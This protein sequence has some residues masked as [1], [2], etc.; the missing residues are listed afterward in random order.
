M[1]HPLFIHCSPVVHSGLAVPIC[2]ADW[3]FMIVWYWYKWCHVKFSDN[4][5]KGQSISHFV[6]SI[7]SLFHTWCVTHVILFSLNASLLDKEVLQISAKVVFSADEAVRRSKD[8][9]K[10]ILVRIETSPDDIHGLHA[11]E[12]VLTTRGVA[13]KMGRGTTHHNITKRKHSCTKTTQSRYN[14]FL[15]FHCFSSFFVLLLL[16]L[17]GGRWHDESCCCGCSRNG[18]AMC[19][20]CWWHHGGLRC[21]QTHGGLRH[22]DW[23]TNPYH[24]WKHRRGHGGRG[25]NSPLAIQTCSLYWTDLVYTGCRHNNQIQPN[26]NQKKHVEKSWNTLKFTVN[27]LPPSC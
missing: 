17:P 11:A 22:S 26:D 24:W 13:Q 20:W 12:G 21:C 16:D 25:S 3:L 6:G 27:R 4:L 15:H 23:G 19:G 18:P 2:F 10:V 14:I 9:D 1:P 7:P 5:D 8:G